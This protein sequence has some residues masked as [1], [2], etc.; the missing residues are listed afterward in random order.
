MSLAIRSMEWLGP[1]SLFKRDWLSVCLFTTP[2]LFSF[3][4]WWDQN[5][6]VRACLVLWLSRCLFHRPGRTDI[7]DH[8]A[9]WRPQKRS[10]AMHQARLLHSISPA[11]SG[12]R[13]P[14]ILPAPFAIC[15]TSFLAEWSWEN[16]SSSERT[17]ILLKGRQTSLSLDMLEQCN[18][19]EIFVK[20]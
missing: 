15:Q 14:K 11:S 16:T 19:D 12:P 8:W 18:A 10:S 5:P 2:Q 1:D 4:F 6:L 3:L 9:Q 20:W 17:I 7:H 13:D